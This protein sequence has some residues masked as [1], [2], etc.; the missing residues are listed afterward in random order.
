LAKARAKNGATYVEPAPV[1][2]PGPPLGIAVAA[3][4]VA[5]VVAVPPHAAMAR[6]MIAAA[7]AL[8]GRVPCAAWPGQGLLLAA[9]K[10]AR[11]TP[12]PA[13]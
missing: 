13:R 6:T 3:V 4:L 7:A 2:M 10:T 8:I 11:R 9:P 1:R 5:G 12:T